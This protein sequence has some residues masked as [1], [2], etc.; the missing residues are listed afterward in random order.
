VTLRL[1]HCHRSVTPEFRQ[2]ERDGALTLPPC[3]P[4]GE[5]TMRATLRQVPVCPPDHSTGDDTVIAG[6]RP[7]VSAMSACTSP[8]RNLSKGT[9]GTKSYRIFFRPIRL[10]LKNCITH[11]GQIL[12]MNLPRC[13][14]TGFDM[15]AVGSC[16]ARQVVSSPACRAPF[17]HFPRDGVGRHLPSSRGIVRR[18]LA[19][20]RS[21]Q[22]GHGRRDLIPPA[23]VASTLLAPPIE[24]I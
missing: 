11:D 4:K 2:G 6:Q 21:L 12:P 14:L 23:A 13:Y 7:C 1:E 16:D 22:R 3:S 19:R 17:P 5:N 10:T 20:E 24:R 15:P 18:C 9:E 8:L